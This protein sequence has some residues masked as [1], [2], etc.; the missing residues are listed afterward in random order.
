MEIAKEH[1]IKAL[2]VK[3]RIKEEDVNVINYHKD[4]N[5]GDRWLEIKCKCGAEPFKV[6][7]MKLLNKTYPGIKCKKCKRHYIGE[8]P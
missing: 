3:V 1:Y 2:G 4:S 5:V 7:P 6:Q 8:Y